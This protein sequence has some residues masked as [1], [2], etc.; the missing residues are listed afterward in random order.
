MDSINLASYS[1]KFRKSK[2]RPNEPDQYLNWDDLLELKNQITFG[3]PEFSDAISL[4]SKLPLKD[5]FPDEKRNKSLMLEKVVKKENIFYGQVYYGRHGEMGKL[6]N[7]TSGEEENITE[8][9]SV[10]NLFYFLFYFHPN[11]DKGILILERKGN[12]GMKHIFENWIKIKVFNEYKN[13]FRVEIKDMV[14][15]RLMSEFIT[16]GSIKAFEFEANKSHLDNVNRLH[17]GL[18]EIKGNFDIRFNIDEPYQEKAKSVLNRIL[19]GEFFKQNFSD[20]FVE[21]TNETEEHIK[22]NVNYKGKNRVFSLG[23]SDNF[24]PYFDITEDID[25]IVGGVPDF[26]EMTEISVKYAEYLLGLRDDFYG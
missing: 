20:N 24:K 22:V 4:L 6:V 11:D 18:N 1:V 21:I 5:I 3:E 17:S 2:K 25:S 8:N 16:H 23:S 9:K 13:Y 15:T 19:S 7:L 12:R 14:P 26:E 10:M